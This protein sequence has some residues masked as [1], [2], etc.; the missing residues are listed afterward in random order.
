MKRDSLQKREWA[1]S[2]YLKGEA[3]NVICASLGCSRAWLYKW[4]SRYSANDPLIGY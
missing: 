1:V 3:P 2:K 4:V